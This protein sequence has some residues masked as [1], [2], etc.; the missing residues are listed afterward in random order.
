MRMPGS[1]N[2]DLR[3]NKDFGALGF[4]YS[5]IVWVTNVF[6]TKNVFTVHTDTGRPDTRMLSGDGLIITG[7]E[8][9]ANPKHWG[10]GRN[11]K[12][13]LSMSF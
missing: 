11:I 2:M 6:D 7:M 4:N 9:D 12:V 8:H 13:G 5:F 1:S 10:P 3:F